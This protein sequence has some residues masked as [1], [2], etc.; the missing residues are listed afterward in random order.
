MALRPTRRIALFGA[1][2]GTGS[3]TVRSFIKRQD[4]RDSPNELRLLVRSKAKL[5]RLLPE[6]W[7]LSNIYIR[8]GQLTDTLTMQ[9]CLRDADTIICAV[10]KNNNIPGCHVLQDPSESIIDGL[11]GLK[12]SCAE[13]WKRPGVILLSS[14]TWNARFAAQEPSLILR[15]LKIA[16]HHPYLD[17]RLATERL[18]ASPELVSLLLVQPSALVEDEPTGMEISTDS[19]S[20]TVSY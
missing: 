18:Q 5:Y 9:D 13:D 3:A 12:A 10:G 16:F 11:R 8:E 19:V 7:S 6:L 4:F 17:L 2:G 15:L 1:T 20:P 14:S